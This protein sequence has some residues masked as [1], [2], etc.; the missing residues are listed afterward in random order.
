MYDIKAE[1]YFVSRNVNFAEDV[2]PFSNNNKTSETHIDE[3][4]WPLDP[5]N[6]C[7][8]RNETRNIVTT[9]DLG[10]VGVVN[11]DEDNEN[12]EEVNAM[13]QQAETIEDVDQGERLDCQQ[14]VH[15]DELLGRG[16]RI[17]KPSTRLKDHVT[18]TA[19]VSLSTSSSLHSKSSGTR[20][21][22]AHFVNCDKFSV[23]HRAFLAAITAGHEP[24]S[25]A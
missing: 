24:N 18:H 5:I 10:V 1:E 17:K 19:T 23:Q 20:Y 2:F 8:E 11:D 16:H 7:E 12:Q 13:G 4:G 6:E 14:N 22:I 21:P 9:N 15:T 25:F 3:W